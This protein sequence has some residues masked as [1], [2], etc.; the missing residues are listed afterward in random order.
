MFIPAGIRT[1]LNLK[2]VFILLDV[3]SWG[4]LMCYFAHLM[5]HS[6]YHGND[7]A[8]DLSLLP[9]PTPTPTLPE[10][11]CRHGPNVIYSETYNYYDFSRLLLRIFIGKGRIVVLFRTEQRLVRLVVWWRETGDEG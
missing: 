4:C 2:C 10:P 6:G 11:N 3:S 8:L 7:D 1:R 9:M 5:F